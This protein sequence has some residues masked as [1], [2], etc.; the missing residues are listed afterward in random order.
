MSYYRILGFEQ[1]PFSTSPDPNFFYLTQE[2]ESALTNLLI[3]LR[4]R[5]GLSVILGDVGT[6]KTSLSRKLVQCLKERGDFIFHILLDPSFEDESLFLTALARNFEIG[7]GNGGEGRPESGFT[8]LDLKESLERFLYQK[9]VA[10]HQTVVLV[11]DE[12]QKL[13]E[14]SMETLRLL[15]NFETNENKLL[16]LVLLGQLEL[17]AKIMSIPN[18]CDRVSF[19]FTLN[20]LGFRETKDMIQFR[21][22]Q[23][24]YLAA[25]PLFLDEAIGLIHQVSRGYPRRITLLCHRALK[26]LVL[27]NKWAVDEGMIRE[28]VDE[29]VK[30]GWLT[31]VLH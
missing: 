10:Q 3:E 19:R 2:H 8:V 24:G 14:S 5:R 11:V 1:E 27:R 29:D 15:L 13:S 31:Q 16:Q 28:L 20:P 9:A 18:F 25:A 6:G 30:Q 12:A 21:I 4:L 26:N 17:H 23:A 7:S 22:R